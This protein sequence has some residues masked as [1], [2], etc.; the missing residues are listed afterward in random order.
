MKTRAVLGVA[1][2]ASA[3]AVG[4]AL[5]AYVRNVRPRL[6]RW[7]AEDDEISRAMPLDGR[8]TEPDYVTNRAITIDA[9]PPEI[10]LW[11]AQ[12]GE[13][14]R[15]GFYSY[16]WIERLMG[17][18]VKNARTLIPGCPAP[19]AGD[20]LDR[21]GNMR[22]KAVEP[23]RYIVV[24]PPDDES[25]WVEATWCLALYPVDQDHTRLVSRVRARTK[26]RTPAALIWKLLLD[27]GQFFMERKMLLE[28][29]ERAEELARERRHW[30]ETFEFVQLEA[31]KSA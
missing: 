4:A 26:R 18:D 5:G 3:L 6:V 22:V 28:I 10:W 14:P 29:K 11:I 2:I 27:P 30:R 7:G 31:M 24:G 19:Q 9:P 12:M 25:L 1:G 16:E 13:S 15:G 23:G 20:K 8:I 21:K 17:M